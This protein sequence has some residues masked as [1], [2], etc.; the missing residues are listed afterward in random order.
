MVNSKI[1]PFYR[2]ILFSIAYYSALPNG[3][4]CSKGFM[5]NTS[6]KGRYG[7][8]A[9]FFTWLGFIGFGGPQAHIALMQQ[10][11]Q[12]KRGWLSQQEFNEALAA[13]NWQLTSAGFG[14]AV[15]GADWSRRSV[16]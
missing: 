2:F 10:E 7:E 5:Q 3:N 16:L 12:E 11:C 15:C 4:L 1:Y 13:P 14:A 6:E 8:I 9:R